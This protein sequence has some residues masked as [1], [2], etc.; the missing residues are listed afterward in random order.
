MKLMSSKKVEE[1]INNTLKTTHT[2]LLRILSENNID[3]QLVNFDAYI[4]ELT[5]IGKENK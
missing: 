2:L 5:K 1:I 3:S 4:I